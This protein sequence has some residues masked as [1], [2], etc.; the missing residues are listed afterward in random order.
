MGDWENKRRYKFVA[1]GRKW[2][3]SKMLILQEERKPFFEIR[4]FRQRKMK[5]CPEK[6]ERFAISLTLT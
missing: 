6:A 2:H 4:P 1:A 5:M 3:N